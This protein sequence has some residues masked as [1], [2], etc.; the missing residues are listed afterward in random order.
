M[1]DQKGDRFVV[2]T[3]DVEDDLEKS[4]GHNDLFRFSKRS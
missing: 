2:A 1:R 3:V 4:L